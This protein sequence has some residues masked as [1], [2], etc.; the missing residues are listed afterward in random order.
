M[1]LADFNLGL[2]GIIHIKP[3]DRPVSTGLIVIATEVSATLSFYQITNDV[4]SNTDFKPN[5][6]TF[7]GYPNPVTDGVVYFNRVILVSLFDLSGRKI[8]EK[9][10]VSQLEMNYPAGIYL[11]KTNE[12]LVQKVVIK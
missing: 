9:Q 2:E 1:N 12:G 4:L 11:L 3:T 7:L 5:Q 6:N 8:T 10:E